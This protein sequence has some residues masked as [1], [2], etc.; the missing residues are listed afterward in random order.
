V[1]HKSIGVSRKGYL[2]RSTGLAKD[3]ERQKASWQTRQRANV[4]TGKSAKEQEDKGTRGQAVKRAREQEGKMA[5]YQL[6]RSKVQGEAQIDSYERG[7][8]SKMAD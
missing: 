4:Q 7:Q 1:R 2:H 3:L 5:L 8:E 6:F